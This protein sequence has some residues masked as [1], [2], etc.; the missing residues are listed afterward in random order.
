[1]HEFSNIDGR[2]RIYLQTGCG[3]FHIHLAEISTY[4]L[5]W[6]MH[7]ISLSADLGKSRAIVG[8]FADKNVAQ[9][10]AVESRANIGIFQVYVESRKR[11]VPIFRELKSSSNYFQELGNLFNFGT[12]GNIRI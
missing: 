5:I 12:L 4:P 2:D 8:F 9:L 11:A 1:M 3:N 7:T 6:R 10:Y